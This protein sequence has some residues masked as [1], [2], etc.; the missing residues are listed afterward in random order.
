MGKGRC[1]WPR[2]ALFIRLFSRPGGEEAT[3]PVRWSWVR[4]SVRVVGGAIC[5]PR[6]SC[7]PSDLLSIHNSYPVYDSPWSR[8]TTVLLQADEVYHIDTIS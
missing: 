5:V 8:Y 6:A 3:S 1:M 2:S 4:H 7:P